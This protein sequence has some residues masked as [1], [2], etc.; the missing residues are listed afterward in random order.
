MRGRSLL[1]FT[2]LA[3][4]QLG[5][6]A[7]RLAREG[8]PSLRWYARPQPLNHQAVRELLNDG[9]LRLVHGSRA[10]AKEG[11][12]HGR[13]PSLGRKMRGS[14]RATR[15]SFYQIAPSRAS[16]FCATHPFVTQSRGK[17]I[18]T[19]P[20]PGRGKGPALHAGPAVP[21]APLPRPVRRGAGEG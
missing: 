17:R 5:N 21:T 19:A 7:A 9:W 12:L 8:R 3:M 15:V 18:L 20:R 4:R 10:K 1:A 6:D 14:R 13:P 16:A 2:L 11:G